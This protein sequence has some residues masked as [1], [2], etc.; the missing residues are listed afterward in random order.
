[1]YDKLYGRTKE[2]ES[3]K[4]VIDEMQEYLQKISG[5]VSPE[6][7]RLL[8]EHDTFVRE[9]EQELKSGGEEHG[10]AV[11]ELEP[12]VKE[13]ND[14]IPKIT[15]MQIELIV[16]SF[17]ADFTRIATLQMTNSVGGA[18]FR[19]L[20]IRSEERRVGKEGRAREEGGE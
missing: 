9:Y 11:P 10:H 5:N 13:E 16:D 7:R 6:D 4:S 2:S 1:M 19:W 18:R 14:N 3:L 12:G 15:K 20:G 17:K 8:E